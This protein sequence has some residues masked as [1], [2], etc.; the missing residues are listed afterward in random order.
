MI[1]VLSPNDQTF[2][3]Y[4]AALF[5]VVL[6]SHLDGGFG[7]LASGV[8]EP[9][10][11]DVFRGYAKNFFGG[12]FVFFRVPERAVCEGNSLDL[13]GY[14]SCDR[15]VTVTDVRADRTG[16]SIQIFFA[17]FVIKIYALAMGDL[18]KFAFEISWKHVHFNAFLPNSRKNFQLLGECKLRRRDLFQFLQRNL[19]AKLLQMH[20]SIFESEKS[21][22][23]QVADRKSVV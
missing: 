11:T 14:H 6:P 4:A 16:S 17:C 5:E 7:R 23:G 22:L 2:F 1:G 10:M 19:W 18:W 8:D 13:F 12:P 9:D 20:L 15:G 21:V 3:G